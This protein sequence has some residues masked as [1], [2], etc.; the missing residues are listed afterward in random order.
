MR[1]LI[2]QKLKTRQL[3]KGSGGFL[4]LDEVR[5]SG[6]QYHTLGGQG[7]KRITETE[8]ASRDVSEGQGLKQQKR[9]KPLKF[10][11]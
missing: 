5:K 6:T 4:N 3:V 7:F 1:H 8:K 2:A 9:I 11:L 10:N